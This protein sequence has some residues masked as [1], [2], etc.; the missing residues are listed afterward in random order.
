MTTALIS[1]LKGVLLLQ[2]LAVCALAARQHP[3]CAIQPSAKLDSLTE[4][5]FRV[6]GQAHS[7]L[8][9]T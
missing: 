8:R 9:K 6:R 4:A 3:R 7:R 5:A 1:S 2:E